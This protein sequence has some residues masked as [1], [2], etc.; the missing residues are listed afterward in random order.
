MVD[1]ILTRDLPLTQG[2]LLL[3]ALAVISVNLAVDLLYFASDPRLR[4]G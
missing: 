4:Y 2:A 3:F 1:S